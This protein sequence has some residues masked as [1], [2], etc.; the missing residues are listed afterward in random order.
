MKTMFKT[1]LA[2]WIMMGLVS[3]CSKK[4]EV[5]QSE[6]VVQALSKSVF[7]PGES[8]SPAGTLALLSEP[9]FLG[10]DGGYI[11]PPDQSS[12]S[13]GSTGEGGYIPAPGGSTSGGQTDT[14]AI[15]QTVDNGAGSSD[16]G[17][18]PQ[19]VDNGTGSI[20][21]GA[22]P[23][24]VDNGTGSIDTGAVP[25]TVDN[26][27]GSIDTGAV[28]QTVVDNGASSSDTGAIPQTVDNGTGSIDTGAV[29]QTVVDNGAS[30]SDTGAIPQ[31]VV[32]NGVGSSDTGAIPQT[33]DSGTGSI[34]TGAIPQTV[35]DN[36]AGSSDTGAVPQTVVDNGT[37]SIDTGAIPQ[38]VVDNGASS[39]DTGAVPPPVV[40]GTVAV[41][42][43]GH[44]IN[45]APGGTSSG[46]TDSGGTDSGSSSAS[47]SG[48]QSSSCP[49]SGVKPSCGCTP[50]PTTPN[51]QLKFQLRRA[52]S[53]KRSNS[54]SLFFEE[55][56]NPI[57][58][59]EAV[60]N[61]GF[62][63]MPGFY[64][65]SKA[66][67]LVSAPLKGV[68]LMKG[69]YSGLT[70]VALAAFKKS[71]GLFWGSTY[72]D[73]KVCEDSNKNGFCYDEP[74]ANQ[75][76]IDVP[77]L[78]AGSIPRSLQINV[79]SGRSLSKAENPRFCEAQYSPLVMDLSGN[80]FDF[81]GPETGVSFDIDDSGSPIPT[82]WIYSKDDALLV[83]DINANRKIDS[84]AEL[85][86]NAT[87]VSSGQ[88]AINGFEALRALD[89]DANG[90]ITSKD[91]AWTELKLWID[92]NHDGVSQQRE[93]MSLDRVGIESISL[94]YA[95]VM[96]VDQFGNQTRERS[97]FVRRVRSKR[98][99]MTVS[100]VW[101]NSFVS[102]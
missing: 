69:K 57:F 15:P 94:A 7:N 28:P 84:G 24:T 26:G 6:A 37:G 63:A 73:I 18:I 51:Y 5:V 43:S 56:K 93:L 58:T 2:L 40:P 12:G 97:T 67:S 77:D 54:K 11:A 90:F 34:D 102:E 4:N 62:L 9:L 38:T 92:V 86:G 45:S 59:I 44:I 23:Q 41:D 74:A 48:S 47:S 65:G 71:K 8:V 49:N 55:A 10:T 61:S 95:S 98:Y 81:I 64:R 80:G 22:V 25:Q 53:I 1:S 82:G 83:R 100:D 27:T 78:K 79:F 14:G 91:K 96:E 42:D 13:T 33:V 16:T 72:L 32:D 101:F 29:P 36:G 35:V 30:S 31:T 85:F 17:A 39:S 68:D 66:F 89:T 99:V 87:R 60:N 52:C 21:T 3:A 75:L 76:A 88:R 20:D 70:S 50:K 46:G 19:T